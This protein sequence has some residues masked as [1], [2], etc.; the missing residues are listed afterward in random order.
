MTAPS[1]PPGRLNSHLAWLL[2]VGSW[3]S[4]GVITVGLALPILG[5]DARLGA[6]H[7]VSIGIALLIALPTLRVA[8]MGL[9]F[10]LHRDF[11]FALIASIVLAIIVISTLLGIAA[12]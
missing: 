2:G 3:V 4:S 10:L 5:I 7:I 6:A 1:G 9:W 11:D 8:M 12:A